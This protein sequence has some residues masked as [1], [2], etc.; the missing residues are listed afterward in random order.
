MREIVKTKHDLCT[1]CN[2]CVRECP[3]ETANI[4][5]EDESG[6]IKVRI[7]H[8]KCI[9]CGRCVT[10]CRHDARYY[11]D[12]I[13]R[14]FGDLRAG[15]P[16]SLI[17][18]PAVKSNI[19]EYKRLFT[20]FRRLGIKKIYD[21]SLGA[22]ICIW[23]YV[24]Y[25]EKNGA[26]PII[27]QPCPVV[28]TY[29]EIY[30]PDL[31]EYL[32]PV[33]SPMA[34]LA[35]Y[36]KKYEGITDHIAAL[37]PCIAK[38]HEFEGTGLSDYNVTFAKM[39][40]YL[41]T[42]NIE[43]PDEES[44]FDNYEC[45][46]GSL[47]PM[48][49][50]LKENIEFFAGKNI[51]IDRAEGHYLFD[52]L[53]AYASA[54]PEMLPR[55]FD[56]LNCD[57]GCNQGTACANLSNPIN[58]FEIN[59][60]MDTNRNAAIGIRKKKYYDD[61]YNEYD[62]AF[63]FSD[64]L[65]KY[66]PAKAQFLSLSPEDIERAFNLLNK[67]TGEK[68]N[69]DCG[70]CGN[71][72]CHEMARKIALG[73][74]I[75]INCIVRTMEKAEEEHIKAEEE[76]EKSLNTLEQ[77]ATIWNHIE[78]AAMIVDSQNHEILDA[79]PAA[80]NM[81]GGSKEKMIGEKCD[82]FFGAHDCPI[83]NFHQSFD[84]SERQFVKADGT[85]MPVLN[86][87]SKIDYYGRPAFLE[88][89]TDISHLKQIEE[90]KSML[91]A[92]D[93]MRAMLDATPMGAHFWDKNGQIIDC[94]QEVVKLFGM[95]SKQEYMKRY[96]ELSPEFQ[97]DGKPSK[98][99]AAMYIKKAFEEGYQR[100]E[101]MR[102]MP[103]GE[104]IPVEITLVRVDY[105]GE[106]LVAGYTRDLREQKRMIN[107][108]KSTAAQL[109]TVVSN[110]PG[111]IWSVKRDNTIML[112]NG[113]YIEKL[114]FTNDFIEGKDINEARKGNRHA[115]IIENV[116][117]TFEEGPQD[118]ISKIEG[119]IFHSRTGPIFDE[120]GN[121]TGL[122]GNTDDLTE[123]LTLQKDLENA[124]KNSEDAI[125]AL[126]EAQHTTAA[127][128]EANPYIN[129]LFDTDF[130]LI[131]CNPAALSF[132]GFKSKK[133]M[134]AGFAERIAKSTPQFQSDGQTTI[135][136][137]ERF[138]AAVK[139]GAV[140]FDIDLIIGG[141]E[142]NL[143]IDFKKIP[144]EGGFA[145]VGYVYDLTEIH[146]RE[147]E[148]KR[149]RELIELQLTKL[150]LVIR[151]TKIGLWDMEIVQ[152]DPVNPKNAFMWSNEFRYMLG[153]SDETDF[154]NILCSWS[155]LLHPEDKEKTLEAF[156]RH[157]LDKTGKTPYD[158]EYRLQKKT[159]EYSY[160][161]ASGETIRDEC[162]NPIR[163]AGSLADI[164]ETKN[165]LL[166]TE[167]QR[168]EAEAA[169]KAKSG[170]LATMSHE[171][172][173]PMNAILGITEI[174]LQNEGLDAGVAE[175]LGKIYSSGDLLLGIINDILDLSKIEAGKLELAVGR[176]EVAS[177]VSDTAQ[178]NMM[179]IGEKPIE[180]EVNVDEN[181]PEALVGD[182]LRVKQILN[183][184]L[185]NAFKYTTAGTV[186]LSV[187][188]E[189]GGGVLVASVSDT[190]QGMTAEQVEKLFD[191]YSRFNRQ[192]NR[193]TEGTGLGMSITKNLV[194]LMGGEISV[195]SEPGKGSVFTV[196]L[197]Q[198]NA[199]AGALGSEV[200]ESLRQFRE[201]GKSQMKRAQITREAMP[202]GRVLIVDDVETNIY[203]AK[204][205][206]APYELK[207]DSADSGFAAIE[208]VGGGKEYDII[209]MDHM[210]PQ[211]DGIEA[212][213]EIRGMGYAR[214]IVA[215]T[216]NAVAGQADVFLGSGFDDYISKPID[217][218][219]LNAVL[220][221][222]VR[223]RHPAEVVEAARELAEAKKGQRAEVPAVDAQ[224]AEV[225]ARDAKKA[226]EV[227]E[228]I[229][230]RGSYGDEGDLRLYVI[231][232]H[233]MKSALANVGNM[234]LSE[235]AKR[236]EAAGRAKDIEAIRRETPAF[237]DSLRRYADEI[238]PVEAETGEDGADE[239]AA[240]L[241][242]KLLAM[243]SA[244][245]DYDKDAL[246]ATLTGLE[247]MAWSRRTRLLFSAISEHLLHSDFDEI[248]NAIDKFTSDPA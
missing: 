116:Q 105:K 198:G 75:P 231:N 96:D 69:V 185:S 12:D 217:L 94:N 121:V 32:A 88:S 209:F 199:G 19:P 219:Q 237:L 178:L 1:G 10:A 234:E 246:E 23:G 68:Q 174:Q 62:A 9:A 84:R 210:M 139:E 118:W 17:A 127:M 208:M 221:R 6:R 64:F 51:S 184:I 155:D 42:N 59:R 55:V 46:L 93:R 222:L 160:Y 228:G 49:G 159:G 97:P 158:I 111:I 193:T 52:K 101:W 183:N 152:E 30:R 241:S 211:M 126:E 180:F 243:K 170:F 164:T 150:N 85:A 15:K 66:K 215:L 141:A 168:I 153:Y 128:F 31:L 16:I 248:A 102:Q 200:A 8:E 188:A 14:F 18:A 125:I 104:P 224:F 244:S 236:L 87:V 239:D 144:Y 4:T 173:T 227:L 122:V 182:E 216:A 11:E 245:E 130:N 79:N 78:S 186:R 131:D 43:L 151:A 191:E 146:K 56:V 214:P 22:D 132:M 134:L 33:Q 203:V 238:C 220:N 71:G 196:R 60:K 34:S 24:R 7:D 136:I 36:M 179:R 176:Y 72:T 61:L 113:L 48:P 206:M 235:T 81:F 26:R 91:E 137:A 149:A 110:Y 70:A 38:A 37:S 47:F 90:Q 225:F 58:F 82:K 190:G 86:S 67:T 218:R 112:F 129:A 140:K 98:Q 5:Y 53:N 21:V 25:C 95:S 76:H 41:K 115:D 20:Y 192:A 147:M 50:G 157:L 171:I 233:G 103:G 154:P 166:E 100:F 83:L 27:T 63:E 169:S 201:S 247:A 65:R 242:E 35:I 187:W 73:V 108:I 29:C 45:G 135:P 2:R 138:L 107:E 145:I 148:L 142:R 80:A 133:D 162:G 77:F 230:K 123:I 202:Y 226:L 205:L 240:Y 165:I 172:R 74:N 28:V 194:R 207:I 177:F 40:D 212:T 89:F 119:K 195:E 92:T 106:T 175:A 124:L 161:R 3:M 232:A 163:V 143:S 167:R 181:V 117:K 229:A 57:E 189:G 99:T 120:H 109:E 44:G 213:R 204:G 156:E 114:G 39:R 13:D 223:D 197:P 54:P